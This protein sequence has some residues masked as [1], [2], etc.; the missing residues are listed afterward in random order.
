MAIPRLY[1]GVDRQ[2]YVVNWSRRDDRR[3]TVLSAVSSVD[4]TTAYC[5]GLHLN[6]DPSLV[7]AEIERE[8][9]SAGDFDVAPPHRKHARHWLSHDYANSTRKAARSLPAGS[10]RDKVARTYAK[11]LDRDDIE[12][13]DEPIDSEKL[14]D[15]GMQIHSEYML[16]GHFLYLKGL[17]ASVE[18][19]RF[20]LDQ[21]PGLRA[22]CLAAF[23]RRHQSQA[24]RGCLLCEYCKGDDG[25]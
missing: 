5:F 20:F 6:F 9:V 7:P 15:H 1:I 4:N 2:D 16:Y 10:L 24:A 18:K 25:R 22:A 8:A 19:L 13:G 17:T 14:P 3:N 23:F 11:A 21:D 12:A